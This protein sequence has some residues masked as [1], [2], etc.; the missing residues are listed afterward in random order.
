MAIEF[1]LTDILFT[2]YS[3]ETNEQVD[4][5]VSAIYRAIEAGDL[6]VEYLLTELDQQHAVF[7]AAHRGIE[8]H[9]LDLALTMPLDAMQPVMFCMQKDGSGLLVDGSHR[10]VACAMRKQKTIRA[11]V[12]HFPD[13]KPYVVNMPP[14]APDVL[15][16][17][18]SGL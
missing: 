13:W 7:I 10:Y 18:W 4:L 3:P 8:A 11:V 9:R 2:H 17:S 5:N 1:R 6:T 16:K 14:I 12:V 15:L